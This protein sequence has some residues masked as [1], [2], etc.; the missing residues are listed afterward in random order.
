MPRAVD[1][2]Q[3]AGEVALSVQLVQG[4]S[5]HLADTL[6]AGNLGG[7]KVDFGA[8]EHVAVKFVGEFTVHFVVQ[9]E[10]VVHLKLLVLCKPDTMIPFYQNPHSCQG[11][12]SSN[13]VVEKDNL[14]KKEDKFGVFSNEGGQKNG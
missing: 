7:N 2:V 13:S 8:V 10:S 12:L 11:Y 6:H 5:G 3:G 4:I 14:Q 9:A 1:A